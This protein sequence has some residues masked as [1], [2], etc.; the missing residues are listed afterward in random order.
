MEIRIKRV[1]ASIG[2]DGLRILVDR[3]WPRGL[4]KE[5][6]HADLWLRE[7]APSTELRKW[8]GHAPDRWEEF[9]KR[10]SCELRENPEVRHLLDLANEGKITLL[11]SARDIKHN[12]ARALKDFLHGEAGNSRSETGSDDGSDPADG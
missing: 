9:K 8:F 4:S 3:L 5:Q 12:H 2:D 6:V 11:F 1:Y 10:Y 7:V